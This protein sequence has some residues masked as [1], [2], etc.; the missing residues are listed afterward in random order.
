MFM[1]SASGIVEIYGGGGGGTEANLSLEQ[2]EGGGRTGSLILCDFFFNFMA[3]SYGCD[4]GGGG[5]G[6]YKRPDFPVI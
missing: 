1:N 6:E 5:G 2:G 3:T 4:G